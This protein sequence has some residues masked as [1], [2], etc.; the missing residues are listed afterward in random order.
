M[1]SIPCGIGEYIAWCLSN[2]ETNRARIGHTRLELRRLQDDRSLTT[3]ERFS[4][5]SEIEQE[6]H[7]LQ[8][9]T[10]PVNIL[11]RGLENE[12]EA[13]ILDILDGMIG[14]SVGEHPLK[15]KLL[16]KACDHFFPT[17]V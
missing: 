6:I 12:N 4:A 2:Y 5:A 15:R 11:R 7:V 9:R 17:G 16:L 3:E 8:M 1:R 13:D 10:D 14:G